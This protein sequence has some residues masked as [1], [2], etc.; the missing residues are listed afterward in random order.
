MKERKRR[1]INEILVRKRR[2]INE[3]LK[4]VSR[5]LD[6]TS[7][8]RIYDI[9]LIA[10]KAKGLKLTNGSAKEVE[11]FKKGVRNEHEKG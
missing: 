3:L 1:K 11:K 4:R 2:K 10:K 5:I 7:E 6:G 9:L 8:D